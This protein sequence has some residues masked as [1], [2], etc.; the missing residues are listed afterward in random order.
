MTSGARR[1]R[2]AAIPR[3]ANLAF[4]AAL[5]HKIARLP[6][7]RRQGIP[8]GRLRAGAADHGRL[9][10]PPERRDRPAHHRGAARRSARAV[11]R[12]RRGARSPISIIDVPVT[13]ESHA[14]AAQADGVRQAAAGGRD[15]RERPRARCRLRHRLFVR[16]AGASSP[17]ASSRWRRMPR[18]PRTAQ[19]GACRSS[20]RAMSR[21]STGP[22]H[23][24]LARE[25]A[26]RCDP[27]RR[28]ERG[29]AGCA[30]RTAQGWRAAGRGD[31]PRADGQGD[32]LSQGRRGAST[33]L[34]L[35]DAA[36][37]L[38]PGFA[39]RR[40]SCSD[41]QHCARTVCAARSRDCGARC[42]SRTAF[43]PTRP[44]RG[45]KTATARL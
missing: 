35:F 33:A 19:R 38:L 39:S 9:S 7:L 5:P 2:T 18:S 37:P 25:G 44:A 32:D 36:A 21:S 34:P 40:H 16:R 6:R 42:A 4:C 22:L 1:A 27:A 28:R 12:R 15:R 14:R 45:F 8:H 17:A 3:R 30:A 13:D 41:A 23:G 10:G 43:I 24:R 11:R 26:L 20:A 29:R 31:R